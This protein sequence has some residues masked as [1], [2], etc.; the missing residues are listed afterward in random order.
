MKKIW[1]SLLVVLLAFN[2]YAATMFYGVNEDGVTA[3]VFY[4]EDSK[5]F[6]VELKV[7]DRDFGVDVSTELP[8]EFIHLKPYLTTIVLTQE[9]T[10]KGVVYTLRYTFNVSNVR[11]ISE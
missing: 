8:E 4:E 11:M 1:A 9:K 3:N 7:V 5:L 6:V 2:V 10:V